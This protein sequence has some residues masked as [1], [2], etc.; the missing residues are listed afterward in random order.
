M[1]MHV[2]YSNI[3]EVEEILL[4]EVANINKASKI[5]QSNKNNILIYLQP[6][7]NIGLKN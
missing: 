2:S 6:E 7:W 1:N 4:Q 5:K 3:C